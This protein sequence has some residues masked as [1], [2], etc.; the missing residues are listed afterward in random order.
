MN[1]NYELTVIIPAYNEE[2][3]LGI[4]LPPL[5]RYCRENL[6]RIILVNDGSTDHSREFLSSL[7]TEPLL[8]VLHHKLN[9][10]YGAA[11]KTGISACET[12]Y[13]VTF[14]A[15][16]Q[17][18]LEDIGKLLEHLKKN[19][20]D[21]VVGSRKGLKSTSHYRGTGKKIIRLLAKIMM[22]VPIHDIN[23]GLKVY[24][25][26]LARNYLYLLPDTMSFSDVITLIF[27]NH[28]HLV[29]EE[30]IRIRERTNGESTIGLQTAFQTVMEI[31]NIVMLFNPM[32]IFLPLSAMC[33]LASMVWGLPLVWEGRGVSVGSLLGIVSTLIFFLL[34]LITEQLS[35]IRKN[36]NN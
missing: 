22:T 1:D 8:T 17:H 24:R 4:F 23:S 30:S 18:Y 9:K 32:K 27:I 29:L 5:I 13:L 3:N 25:T 33:F 14:D 35:Q 7:A 12:R 28:R 2:K 34:G 26:D 16:G 31:I 6:W 15:D 20:A 19:D 36:R 10:G 21:M 11:L